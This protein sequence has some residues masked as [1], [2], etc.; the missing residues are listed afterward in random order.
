M[1]KVIFH[2]FNTAEK[3][4]NIKKKKHDTGHLRVSIFMLHKGLIKHNSA[5]LKKS[6]Q[7]GWKI[8]L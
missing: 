2:R 3:P 6:E 7:S 1:F 4:E 8:Y 5:S